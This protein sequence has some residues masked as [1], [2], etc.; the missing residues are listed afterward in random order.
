MGGLAVIVAAV[1][2]FA[3][4]AAWYMLLS[5]PW[6]ADSGVAVDA[7]GAPTGRS[8]AVTYGG[9]FLC[10]LVLAGMMRHVLVSS[11]V[12]SAGA[13]LVAGLGVGLF[14]ITPWLL[15]NILC[16]NRPFRLAAIDGGYATLACGATGLVLGL[17]L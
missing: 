9:G 2:G 13:G 10:I 15:L 1:A 17:F 3:V 16:A 6:I 8:M 5:K 7:T 14:I 11:G 12:L 4:G